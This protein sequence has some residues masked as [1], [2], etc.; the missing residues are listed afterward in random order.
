MDLGTKLTR[1]LED[2]EDPFA[3]SFQFLKP[4]DEENA[5]IGE[6]VMWEVFGKRKAEEKQAR[7]ETGVTSAALTKEAVEMLRPKAPASAFKAMGNYQRKHDT[8]I[9]SNDDTMTDID[10]AVQAGIDN[11]IEYVREAT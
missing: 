3:D 8:R 5:T 9:E 10:L 7:K 4:T 2:E 1:Y 6:Q 11:C